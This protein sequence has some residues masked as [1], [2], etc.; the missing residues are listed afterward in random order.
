MTSRERIFASLNHDEPDRIPLDLAST[1]VT[2]ISKIAYENLLKYLGLIDLN[3][4]IC[5]AIQ[6]ICIPSEEILYKFDVDTRGLWPI[7]SHIKFIDED[8]GKYLSHFDEW[9]LG[10]RRLKEG[11]FWYDLFSSPMKGKPLS[12]ELISSHKWP[13][14]AMLERFEGLRDQAI[15]FREAGYAVILKSICAG[16]LEMAIRLRGMEDAL[17]DLLIDPVCASAL[18]DAVL[19]VKIEYW[20]KALDV[21]GD[22]V[23]VVAEADDFGSQESQLISPEMFRTVIK[24]AQEQLISFLKK[25][26]PDVY[27]FFHSC[28]NVRDLLPD[29]IEM[30][31]DI[32]NPV[33]ITAQGMDPVQLKKDFGEDIVFWGGGVDTQNTLPRGTPDQVRDEVKRNIDILAPGGG[34]VFNTIHNIQADVPPEN[35]VAI[36]E[37]LLEFGRY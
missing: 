14:G 26:K 11:A 37:T 8:D 2:G 35:I 32:I 6:Q 33:H 31:I 36:Y 30:G 1:Q 21:L 24:P 10:Y 19:Q 20:D 34:F 25:K 12:P 23:D 29:F 22:V 7:T 17:T 27:V 15:K 28:G 18:L 13:K 5:D 16:N 4:T 3:I 9:G